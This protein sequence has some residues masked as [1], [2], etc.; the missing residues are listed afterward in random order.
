[1]ELSSTGLAK[2]CGRRYW[3]TY[4]VITENCISSRL[5]DVVVPPIQS[6]L[7]MKVGY[8]FEALV[9]DEFQHALGHAC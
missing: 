4:L 8:V 9:I 2:H 5:N 3:A 6:P 1:M 7:L